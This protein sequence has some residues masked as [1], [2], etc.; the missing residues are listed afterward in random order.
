MR[1]QHDLEAQ[2]TKGM[3][4]TEE[5]AKD[6]VLSE[7]QTA[8]SVL[9]IPRLNEAAASLEPERPALPLRKVSRSAP[10][11]AASASEG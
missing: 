7:G 2:L 8:S 11:E 5:A 6:V 10:R 1:G 9:Y 3:E 4:R